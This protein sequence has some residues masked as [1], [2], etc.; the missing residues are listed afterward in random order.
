[1]TRIKMFCYLGTKIKMMHI[2]TIP[3]LLISAKDL[4][5]WGHLDF[6]RMLLSIYHPFISPED[7]FMD[8]GTTS[9]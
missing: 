6:R 3:I 8:S 2:R 1:M 5:A 7:K 9:T 4:N